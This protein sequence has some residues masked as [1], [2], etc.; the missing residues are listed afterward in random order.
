MSR[1]CSGTRSRR[2]TA[3]SAVAIEYL[4][5]RQF[6]SA[7]EPQVVA[8]HL[9]VSGTWA[10][11]RNVEVTQPRRLTNSKAAAPAAAQGTSEANDQMPRPDLADSV[12]VNEAKDVIVAPDPGAVAGVFASAVPSRR[13]S[14]A[15]PFA[16]EPTWLQNR[17]QL[18]D[19]SIPPAPPSAQIASVLHLPDDSISPLVP[20][21]GIALRDVSVVEA[22]SADCHTI[23]ASGVPSAATVWGRVVRVF[24]GGEM[25]TQVPPN[26]IF[27]FARVNAAETFSDAL[28]R[29]IN[30][31]A[32]IG[33]ALT[34]AIHPSHEKAWTITLAVIAGD[35]ALGAYMVGTTRRRSTHYFRSFRWTV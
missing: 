30:Q 32:A 12:I 27:D 17:P 14:A 3:L 35:A 28:S 16:D 24:H 18:Q 4:E 9:L 7:T 26:I 23:G 15:I 1:A 29:F 25:A 34:A 19:S 33:P 10:G 2:L 31:S 21:S 5:P 11:S 13:A 20:Y 22:V 6:L 8:L